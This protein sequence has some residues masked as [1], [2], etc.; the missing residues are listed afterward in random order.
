IVLRPE[1]EAS[2]SRRPRIYWSGYSALRAFYPLLRL[3]RTSEL[4]LLSTWVGVAGFEPT[5][6]S[7]R[8]KRATKL[9]H[10]PVR[11]T[12]LAYPVQLAGSRAGSAARHQREQCRLGPAGEADRSERVGA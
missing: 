2:A 5:A 6:S 3:G 4:A 7:S 9:R 1:I 10:T 12:G 11:A 8:T